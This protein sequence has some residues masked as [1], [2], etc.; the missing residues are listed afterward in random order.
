MAII[1]DITTERNYQYK[2]QYCRIERVGATK[3][4]MEIEM[5]VYESQ[6]LAVSG[7]SPHRYEIVYGDFLLESE[8]NPWQQGYAILKNRWP[9]AVDA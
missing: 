3:A 7:G 9:D 4:R 8:L 2:Q 5:G 1:T 6:E